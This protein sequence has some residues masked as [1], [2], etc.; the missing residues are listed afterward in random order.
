MELPPEAIELVAQLK[1]QGVQIDENNPD[2]IMQLMQLLTRMSRK[3]ELLP[4]ENC[5]PGSGV[6]PP[7][8]PKPNTVH[9]TKGTPLHGPFD[10]MHTIM[11]GMGCFW[12][13]ENVFMQVPEVY[14]TQ[15][16]YA[17]GPTTNPTYEQVC[18]GRTNHNEVVRVVYERSDTLSELLRLF[19]ERH[20]PTTPFQQGN[21]RGT[22]YRSGIYWTTDEQRVAAEETRDLYQQAIDAKYGPGEKQISTEIVEAPRFW[23]AEDYHQQYDAKPT[24]N[25]YCGLAPLFGVKLPVKN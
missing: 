23:F 3:V 20:N 9:F 11:F 13:S 2:H 22:Q 21:D 24:G 4:P 7:E 6:S 5:L 8:L 10:G 12:C 18:S 1:S 16:G 19:W 14:S 17:G 25:P 15:V